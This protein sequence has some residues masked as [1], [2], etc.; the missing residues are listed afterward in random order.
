MQAEFWPEKQS[1]STYSFD[2]LP[3]V[4]CLLIRLLPFSLKFIFLSFSAL[5]LCLLILSKSD[6]SKYS[7]SCMI[8]NTRPYLREKKEDTFFQSSHI[9]RRPQNLKKKYTFLFYYLISNVR[10]I[11]SNFCGL[12]RKNLIL[13]NLKPDAI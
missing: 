5:L 9:V 10:K 4:V 2:I 8:S 6:A 1:E 3:F 13:N 12:L 7:S 11:D